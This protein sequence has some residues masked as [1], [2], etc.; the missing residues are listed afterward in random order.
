MILGCRDTEGINAMVAGELNV[1][2]LP[3]ECRDTEWLHA[4]VTGAL[5]DLK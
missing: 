3:L 2:K 4:L 1:F 5:N